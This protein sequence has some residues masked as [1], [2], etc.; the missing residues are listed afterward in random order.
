M[1]E[2]GKRIQKEFFLQ[3]NRRISENELDRKTNMFKVVKS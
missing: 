2:N 3:L 1:N